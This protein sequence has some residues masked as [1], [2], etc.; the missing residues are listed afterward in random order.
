MLG[1]YCYLLGG[2]CR[3]WLENHRTNT[4]EIALLY[5]LF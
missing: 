4:K 3:D 5:Q 2:D 1:V